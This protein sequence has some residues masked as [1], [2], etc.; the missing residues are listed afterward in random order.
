MIGAGIEA[1]MAPNFPEY[2]S[3]SMLL[4]HINRNNMMTR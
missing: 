4:M 3:A 2:T 1:K